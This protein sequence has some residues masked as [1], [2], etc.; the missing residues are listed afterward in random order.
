MK[1]KH[2]HGGRTSE[3]ILDKNIILN[4]LKIQ[5]GQNIL[6]AG[7]GNGYMSK[8]FSKLAGE[9]GKVYAMDMYEQSINQLKSETAGTNITTIFGDIAKNIEIEDSSIDLVY[10]SMVFHGF[11]TS[12]MEGFLSEVKRLLKPGGI[13]AVVEINKNNTS[14]GPPMNIRYSPE[15]LIETVDLESKDLT[16]IGD[17]LYMQTFVY[18]N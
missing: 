17:D 15:E 6:D 11:T 4:S 8:E 1:Q 3:S 2:E 5:T 18:R 12:Q 7:C 16:N 10:L 14:F 9:T 13:L